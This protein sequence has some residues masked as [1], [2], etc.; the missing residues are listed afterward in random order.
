M[1]SFTCVLQS[2]KD[3]GLGLHVHIHITNNIN[4]CHQGLHLVGQLCARQG[5]GRTAKTHSF[6][7]TQDG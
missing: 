5:T 7:A 1:A 6:E 3:A 2:K 4:V